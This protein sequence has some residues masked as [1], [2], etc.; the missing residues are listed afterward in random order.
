MNV[1]NDCV[2]IAC[3]YTPYDL[4]AQLAAPRAKEG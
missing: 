3:L 1:Y 4:I 2:L